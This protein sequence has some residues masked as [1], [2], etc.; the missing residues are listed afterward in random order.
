MVFVRYNVYDITWVW[1]FIISDKFSSEEFDDEEVWGE[2]KAQ[3]ESTETESD[4]DSD[5]SD[6]TIGEPFSLTVLPNMQ[7][8]PAVGTSNPSIVSTPPASAL[9]SKLFPK[10]KEKPKV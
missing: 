4:N 10:L 6:V 2:I 5:D 1:I 7:Q 8:I 3:T 9:M